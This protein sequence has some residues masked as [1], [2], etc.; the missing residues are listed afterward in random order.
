MA[1]GEWH[2]RHDLPLRTQTLAYLF[3]ALHRSHVKNVSSR[4]TSPSQHQIGQGE[5]CKKLCSVLGQAAIV[6][7]TMTE[8]VLDDMK[9][10]LDF[11]TNAGLPMLHLFNQATQFAFG[12][13][14]ALE[15]F[16]AAC[17]ATDLPIFS[18]R[19]STPW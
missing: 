7:F 5:Q 17:Q 19:F 15:R 1:W 8:Q 6:R 13:R 3:D 18:D 2:A 10:M 12:Q 9:R 4:K 11:R 16:I 14:F